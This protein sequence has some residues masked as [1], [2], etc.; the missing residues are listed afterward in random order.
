MFEMFVEGD[1]PKEE[2]RQYITLTDFPVPVAV[3]GGL[4][5]KRVRLVIDVTDYGLSPDADQSEFEVW[6]D[7][8]K[9]RFMSLSAAT[10]K[11][12]ADIA[13]SPEAQQEAK[14]FIAGLGRT[15]K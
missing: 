6:L 15:I 14:D 4:Y 8:D 10:V 11:I 7:E 3:S 9:D 2:G 12:A 5:V 13:L 1:R